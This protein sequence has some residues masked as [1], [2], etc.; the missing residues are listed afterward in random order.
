MG[1]VMDVEFYNFKEPLRSNP[2]IVEKELNSGKVSDLPKAKQEGR[3]GSKA[4]ILKLVSLDLKS[5]D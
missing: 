2:N 1:L 4:V 5:L 3:T